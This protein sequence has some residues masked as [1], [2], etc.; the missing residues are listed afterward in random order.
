MPRSRP[1]PR[2]HHRWL[3]LLGASAVL[4]AA[5]GSSPS[6]SAPP[7]ATPTATPAPTA[8]PTPT[9]QAAWVDAVAALADPKAVLKADHRGRRRLRRQGDDRGTYQQDGSDLAL[10]LDTN[11]AGTNIHTEQRNVG[12]E[13]Y[14][15]AGPLWRHELQRL[16]RRSSGHARI[17]HGQGHRR[18]VEGQGHRRWPGRGALRA[19]RARHRGVRR[20]AGAGRSRSTVTDARPG[21][22]GRP[23]MASRS[24]S[25]SS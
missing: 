24:P 11:L 2:P 6:T 8:T 18:H 23:P 5:C 25:M 12:T 22:P 3:T 15:L 16:G 4:V 19:H 1:L 7:S 14:L 17:G 9:P 10:V 13:T 21:A 20:G